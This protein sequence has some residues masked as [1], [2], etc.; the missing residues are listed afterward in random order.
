M[1]MSS[2]RLLI[3]LLASTWL[4][5][6]CDGQ[7][8]QTPQVTSAATSTA[9]ATST[10]AGTTAPSS[11]AAAS[12]TPSAIASSSTST[13]TDT[14]ASKTAKGVRWSLGDV[15]NDADLHEHC[16]QRIYPAPIPGQR[17]R[18]I[19]WWSFVSKLPTKTLTARFLKKKGN[20]GF[21]AAPGGG[22]RWEHEAVSGARSSVT[23][24]PLASTHKSQ[25]RC[26]PVPGRTRTVVIISFH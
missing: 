22:G 10:A 4:A 25:L 11:A 16:E 21:T 19:S 18:H 5:P 6:G 2:N 12:A 3:L 24:R 9:P 23:I 14:T 8:A 13:S 17:M 1:T 20:S 26:K 7:P 15:S